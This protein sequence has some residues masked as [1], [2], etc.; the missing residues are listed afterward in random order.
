MDK[1]CLEEA[2]VNLPFFSA[3]LPQFMAVSDDNGAF[4]FG[5]YKFSFSK[6]DVSVF[7]RFPLSWQDTGEDDEIPWC[8]RR[9][10]DLWFVLLDFLRR[11]IL[12]QSFEEGWGS[13]D[14]EFGIP[15]NTYKNTKYFSLLVNKTVIVNKWILK[16]LNENKLTMKT[17]HHPNI[18]LLDPSRFSC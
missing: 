16:L 8:W 4:L 14:K 6:V 12:Y 13:G 2:Q 1:D 7:C 3:V 10:S 15:L 9:N 18:V 11:C 5:R 17:H